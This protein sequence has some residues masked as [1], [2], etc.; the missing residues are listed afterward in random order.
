LDLNSVEKGTIASA[1]ERNKCFI[2]NFVE[3]LE[4][5]IVYSVTEGNSIKYP[6]QKCVNC[7]LLLQFNKTKIKIMITWILK[8]KSYNKAKTFT[9]LTNNSQI[10]EEI[11]IEIIDY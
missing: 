7:H 4:K 10:S 5:C 8:E 6:N 2:E 1:F 3:H 9:V 11:N